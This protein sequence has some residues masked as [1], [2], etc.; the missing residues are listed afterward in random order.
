MYGDLQHWTVFDEGSLTGVGS[1]DDM[2]WCGSEPAM[3]ALEHR[4]SCG[5]PKENK[6]VSG[7]TL[8]CVTVET[9]KAS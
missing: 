5:L 7:Y 3:A 4:Q 6:L 2:A 1:W 8:I 9:P